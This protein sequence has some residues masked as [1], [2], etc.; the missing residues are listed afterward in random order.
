M[1]NE[2]QIVR[3]LNQAWDDAVQRTAENALRENEAGQDMLSTA[4]GLQVQSGVHAGQW[5]SGSCG[6]CEGTCAAYC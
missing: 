1:K 4:S 2:N 6:S 3:D 5:G